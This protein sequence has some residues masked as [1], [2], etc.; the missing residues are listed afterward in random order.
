[1]NPLDSDYET[2]MIESLDPPEIDG[3]EAYQRAK[4]MEGES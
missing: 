4:D 1:M 3:D 2:E